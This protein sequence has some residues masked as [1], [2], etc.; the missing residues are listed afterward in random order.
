[1]T[2]WQGSLTWSRIW[3]K[4][5]LKKEQVAHVK[6]CPHYHF[7]FAKNTIDQY[8]S[9]RHTSLNRKHMQHFTYEQGT[10]VVP[11]KGLC[12]KLPYPEIMLTQNRKR[13]APWNSLWNSTLDT[14]KICSIWCRMLKQ[15]VSQVWHIWKGF[16]FE[17]N[18]IQ[19]KRKR[20]RG[21]LSLG[22]SRAKLAQR[23]KPAQLGGLPRGEP[24]WAEPSCP[25]WHKCHWPS[26]PAPQPPVK[27]KKEGKCPLRD[28]NLQPHAPAHGSQP[29]C[30][31]VF[32]DR[33][34]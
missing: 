24:Y 17:L 1:M 31:W 26:W 14:Y 11:W 9:V 20:K 5:S 6:K 16:E 3:K 4:R 19:S 23:C 29:L 13:S 30:H 12:A 2:T 32:L 10:K 34:R 33:E 28:S 27:N 8:Q 7:V 15:Q 21:K 22:C 18:Q 25:Q